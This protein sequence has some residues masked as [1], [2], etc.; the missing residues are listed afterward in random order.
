MF[1]Q[2]EFNTKEKMMQCFEILRKDKA[3]CAHTF[4]LVSPEELASKTKYWVY[5]FGKEKKKY[6][7]EITDL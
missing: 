2:V 5:Y 6:G 7:R 4:Y 3:R 1:L